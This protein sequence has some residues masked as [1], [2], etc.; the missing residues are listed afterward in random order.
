MLDNIICHKPGWYHPKD[1]YIL[2]RNYVGCANIYKKDNILKIYPPFIP[3]KF[4]IEEDIFNI[5]K[6]INDNHFI[7]L[8]DYY[9]DNNKMIAYTAKYIENI[10]DFNIFNYD[11]ELIKYNLIELK[12][13]ILLFTK[14]NIMI[15]DVC[16]RNYL[17]HKDKLVIIDPDCY[18]FVDKT[19]SKDEL[20]IVNYKKLLSSFKDVYIKSFYRTENKKMGSEEFIK[21]VDKLFE[22]DNIE[23]IYKKI[24][25]FNLEKR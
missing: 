14:L 23:N 10:N 8:E 19:I 4:R 3:D 18:R 7:K 21:I 1:N 2:L 6:T 12:K 9:K 17:L 16:Y 11:K 25:G 22:Y 13:L 24:D 5:L 20:W 15:E